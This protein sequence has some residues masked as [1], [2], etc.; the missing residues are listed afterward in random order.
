MVYTAITSDEVDAKSPVD[1]TLMGKVKDNL[2]DHETRIQVLKS[3]PL[4]WRVNGDLSSLVPYRSKYKR[5]DGLRP[6]AAQTM[7][8]C[9]ITLDYPG[10]SGS[11]E[12][13]IRKYRPVNHLVNSVVNLFTGSINSITNVAPALAT[14]S[15]TRATT[16]ISTQSI[17]L[18]KAALNVQ[19]II[20]L[21]SNLVRYNLDAAPD[22][23]WKVGKTV[24][25]ASCTD[26]ANNISGT[27]VRI[28]D[29]GGY[30]VVVTNA[31]GVAQTSA[32]G[33][34]TLRAYSYNFTNP[35]DSHFTIGESAVFASHT[36]GANDGTF[37]IA[38]VNSGGNN[39][40]VYNASGAVQA[41]VA[42]NVNVLRFVYSFSSAASSTDFVVGEKARMA[43]H[44]SG[45]NDGNLTLVAVNSGGNNV[46]V[47]NA[48]GAVQGGVAGTVNTN[49]W[50]YALASDPSTYFSAAQSMVASSASSGGNNGTF[51]VKEVNRLGTNNLVVYN[52]SG[53]TQAGAAGSVT[54]TR[55]VY[56]LASDLSSIYTTLSNVEFANCPSDANNGFFDVVA[57]NFGGGS[58]HNIVVENSSGVTQSSPAGRII[59][60]SKSLF[61]T[62]PKITFPTTGETSYNNTTIAWQTTAAVFDTTNKIITD[63]EVSANVVLGLDIVSIPS[64][65]PKNLTVQVA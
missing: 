65:T 38:A 23:Y 53:V 64:G 51:T 57:V 5:L 60:E 4:E 3:F 12:I 13:D 33:T 28:N 2:V 21:G 58:N 47:Y 17:S 52:E 19:S 35:V 25:A 20:L 16:Q 61:S 10:T 24:T 11:L 34:L 1:D 31:S 62:R 26:G 32:A 45:S 39:I 9:N 46:I 54:H 7:S 55:W 49:R 36:A 29:D 6:V 18:F 56:S 44:T 48:S 43:S 41:G 59:T 15:I 37:E 14:Q 50:I 22:S 8:Q 42:G 30:N 27:I 40:A 63:D